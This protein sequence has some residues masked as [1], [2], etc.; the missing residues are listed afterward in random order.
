MAK[1]NLLSVT[2]VEKAK[3]PLDKP[4]KWFQDGG[5]LLLRVDQQQNKTWTARLHKGGK[6]TKRGI[7]SYPDVSLAQ[8]REIRDEFKKLWIQG[9]DPKVEKEKSKFKKVNIN[10]VTFAQAYED[11]FKHYTSKKI[12]AWSRSHMKRCQ[13]IYTNY[14]IKPLGKLP[15]TEIDDEMILQVLEGIYKNAPVTCQKAKH[16][17]S[18][19]FNYAKDKRTF[20]GFNPVMHLRSNSLIAPSKVV[21]HKKELPQ[22]QVGEFLFKISELDNVAIKHYLYVLL[23]T[24]LRVTSLRRATWGMYD[25]KTNTL[26]IPSENMKNKVFFKCPLPT[27]AIP[28]LNELKKQG[29]KVNERIFKGSSNE[30]DNVGCISLNTPNLNIKRL[31]FNADAHGVRTTFSRFMSKSKKFSIEV[32]EAQLSHKFATDQRLAYLGGETFYDERKEA[33]QYFADWCDKELEKYKG[34]NGTA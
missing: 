6:E 30:V 33:V 7:G 15:L 11:T 22:H 1:Q 34:A 14:L 26:N 28:M 23:T 8:A 17:I 5:G 19:V 20:R 10:A 13:S 4:Y 32:S 27:Q 2:K 3:C 9:K 21:E 31:R 29:D 18:V 12:D 16:L 24:A 25:T